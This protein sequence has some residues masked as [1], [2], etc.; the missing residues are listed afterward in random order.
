MVHLEAKTLVF[1]C[2]KC[3]KKNVENNYTVQN[4]EA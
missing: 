3:G 1:V 2:Q 4:S